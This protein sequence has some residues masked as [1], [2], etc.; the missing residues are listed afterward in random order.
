[1][2]IFFTWRD[3]L[4]AGVPFFCEIKELSTCNALKNILILL[5][6]TIVLRTLFAIAV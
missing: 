1:M 4:N 6:I 5:F 2:I 3:L